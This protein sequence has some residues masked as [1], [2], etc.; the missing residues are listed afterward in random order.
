MPVESHLWF[1]EILEFES[2]RTI[3][4]KINDLIEKYDSKFQRIE[5]YDTKPFGKMLVLEGIIMCTEWDEFAYHE[6]ITHVPMFVHPKPEE[7]LIIGGGD[8]GTAREVLKH[9]DVKKVDICEIDEDVV[10]ICRKHLPTMASS[11]D[12]KR[13]N[14]YFEDGAKF[15][16]ERKDCYD[17]IIVDSSDPI[18]TAEVLFREDFYLSLKDVLKE[19]GIAVTQSESYFYDSNL[20]ERITGY[21]K[22]YYEVSE[23]YFTTV[24]TYP[25]GVIGFSFCSKKYHPLDHLNEERVNKLQHSFK[26]YN[27]DIHRGSFALPSFIKNR[28]NL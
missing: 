1:E 20:V 26:Y 27:P 9:S 21:S 6:M 11:F 17:V 10:R 22:K 8:G 18:G 4:I 12:D 7:I 2:G 25:S 13:I 5:I 16:K 24:P 14:I 19:E 15:V 28:I 23:Y 3:K